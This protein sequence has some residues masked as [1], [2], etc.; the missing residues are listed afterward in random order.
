MDLQWQ[1][2]QNMEE[3]GGG[4]G[5]KLCGP[6]DVETYLR[7]AYHRHGLIQREIGCL[8]LDEVDE[9]RLGKLF[10]TKTLCLMVRDSE[11]LIAILPVDRRL[12]VNMVGRHVSS[13]S[14]SSSSS[15]LKP[16]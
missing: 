1:S 13:S 2:P 16:P 12:D 14:S 5:G 11:P 9:E 10:H 4:R 15:W 6:E 8:D 3:V 7:Q